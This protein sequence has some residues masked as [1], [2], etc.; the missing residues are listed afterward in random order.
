MRH[1]E[2]PQTPYEVYCYHCRVTFPAQARRCVHCGQRLSGRE[3]A[4]ATGAEVR[5]QPDR[6]GPPLD[7]AEEEGDESVRTLRRFGVPAVWAL[8]AVSAVLANLCEGRG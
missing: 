7:A 3:A 4:P 2:G 8:V 5:A 6:L 1:A